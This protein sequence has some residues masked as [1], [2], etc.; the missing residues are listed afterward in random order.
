MSKLLMSLPSPLGI[1][2]RTPNVLN[3]LNKMYLTHF[4][5]YFSH[6]QLS[7]TFPKISVNWQ[8]Y[9]CTWPIVLSTFTYRETPK[10][11]CTYACTCT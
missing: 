2:H 1:D 7:C 9:A 8:V 10:R 3:S 6:V 11:G 5:V 4:F